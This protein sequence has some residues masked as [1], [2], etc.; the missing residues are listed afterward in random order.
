M[1]YIV[2]IIHGAFWLKL[3][4][5]PFN[6]V[7]L[8]EMPLIFIV[9][10]YSYALFQKQTK[11]QINVKSYLEYA[12]SRL[13]RIYIPYLIYAAACALIVI[14]FSKKNDVLVILYNWFNPFIHGT[15]SSYS[16]LTLHLWFINPFILVTLFLPFITSLKY[17][18]SPSWLVGIIVLFIICCIEETFF[19]GLLTPIFY[20]FWAWFGYQLAIG[21]K[22]SR[23]R[24][25][26]IMLFCISS[27]FA[28]SFFYDIKLDMQDNKFPPNWIFFIFSTIWVMFLLFISSFVNSS[29]IDFIAD[30]KWFRPFIVSGY[31]IYLWQGLGYSVANH[32]GVNG[33]LPIYLTWI[34]AIFSTVVLGVFFGRFETIRFRVIND[35]K[36]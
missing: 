2:V 36:T 15:D 19:E 28:F 14:V 4:P 27:L 3:I 33:N 7:L 31:S 16:F 21:E 29:K 22:Y 20:M 10:G 26:F 25:A 12:L 34:I 5:R 18:N 8:F 6:S 24:C 9:S 30:L 23:V 32:I 17:V 1:L 11:Y 35:K 13:S